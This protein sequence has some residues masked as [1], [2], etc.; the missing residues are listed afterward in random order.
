MNRKI[1]LE[2]LLN[3]SPLSRV[4]IARAT[5]LSPS[6]V[7]NAVSALMAEGLVQEI[8]SGTS[9]AV[10][11]PPILLD[12][13]W[14]SRSVI[15]V[16]VL[17]NHLIGV[18]TNLRAQ[19][20]V[21]FV[22]EIFRDT[23][24]MDAIKAAVDNLMSGQNPS[25]V[26][27]IGIA[28]PGILDRDSGQIIHSANFNWTNVEVCREL[29]EYTGVPTLIENDTNA[30]A[31]G[32]R[33]FGIGR[34]V[35]SFAY[36][37]VGT[38]VGSGIVVDGRLLLGTQ[39][40]AGEIGHMTVDWRGPR[41]TCGSF[42]CLEAYV[43]WWAVKKMMEQNL[44][45]SKVPD[46]PDA[47][48]DRATFIEALFQDDAMKGPL[49]E[50]AAVMGAGVASLV[51]VLNPQLVVVEGIYRNSGWFLEGLK[52]EASLRLANVT[53]TPPV[54]TLGELGDQASALGCI[55][56]VLETNG[57]LGSPALRQVP[58]VH[59]EAAPMPSGR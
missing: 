25:R 45:S 39:G 49:A 44:P 19:I 28:T 37:L 16:S 17:D 6:T 15:G 51:T 58:E 2:T 3:S 4:Q 1:V 48:L 30:A 18:R 52:R 10:G 54:I 55:A 40:M 8:G 21:N 43:S 13:C 32:E 26:I 53:H 35:N 24:I 46:N 38:G 27:G 14:D 20:E 31:L 50:A 34:G 57:L 47:I 36:I 5:T 12:I 11:R 56:L 23:D 22:S 29:T 41:C 33:H 59:K 42:G 7:T 9:M